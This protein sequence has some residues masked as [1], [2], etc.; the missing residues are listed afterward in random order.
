MNYVEQAFKKVRNQKSFD[1]FCF[2]EV[3]M[4]IYKFVFTPQLY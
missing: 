2:N 3:S 4:F 1:I